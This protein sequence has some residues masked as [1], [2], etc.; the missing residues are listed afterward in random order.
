MVAV[1]NTLSV[2]APALDHIS[3]WKASIFIPQITGKNE[4]KNPFFP[5]VGRAF[6]N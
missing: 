5:I 6:E 2:S 4:R 3:H 1:V